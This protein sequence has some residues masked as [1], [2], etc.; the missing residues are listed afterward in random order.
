VPS[1]EG[2]WPR[3][4]LWRRRPITRQRTCVGPSQIAATFVAV[5]AMLLFVAGV[6]SYIPV[7]AAAQ[8]DPLV[9]LR[10]E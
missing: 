10:E 8:A 4:T 2:L 3:L 6:V 1:R 9:S 7:R 5:G